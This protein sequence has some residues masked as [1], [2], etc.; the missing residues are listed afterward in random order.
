[1][2]IKKENKDSKFVLRIA[3]KSEKIVSY[4]LITAYGEEFI[5][6]CFETENRTS[7]M[8]YTYLHFNS[9]FPPT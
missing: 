3:T 5:K 1:M 8:M 2:Y 7:C 4:Y 9:N 6:E